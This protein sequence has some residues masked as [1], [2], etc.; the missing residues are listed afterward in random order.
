SYRVGEQRRPIRRKDPLCCACR[1]EPSRLERVEEQYVQAREHP[2]YETRLSQDGILPRK[3]GDHCRCNR[4]E[5]EKQDLRRTIIFF[6]DRVQ[7]GQ[8]SAHT[9]KGNKAI[10]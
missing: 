2:D 10:G 7:R 3:T 8:Y 5:N 6:P 1:K 9:A 4:Q